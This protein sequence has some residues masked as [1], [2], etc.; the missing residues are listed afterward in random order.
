[1]KC[2]RCH[3]LMVHESSF[4]AEE[5]AVAHYLRCVSCGEV[6]DDIIVRNRMNPIRDMAKAGYTSRG[7]GS[8]PLTM[9]G[10]GL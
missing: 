7:A 5:D 10:S 6:L 3:G 4:V 1:M 9:S 8:V 2:L